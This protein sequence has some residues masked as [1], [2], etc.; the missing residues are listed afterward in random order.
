LKREDQGRYSKKYRRGM[1][2]TLSEAEIQGL[3]C[4]DGTK[5][6]RTVNQESDETQ[7]YEY[8]AS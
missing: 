3:V 1:K 8:P 6:E 7:E 4:V 2:L 5:K